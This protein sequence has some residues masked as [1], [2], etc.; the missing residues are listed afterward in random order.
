MNRPYDAETTKP[1]RETIYNPIKKSLINESNTNLILGLQSNSNYRRVVETT[2]RG[3]FSDIGLL[4][5]Q[6]K[7]TRI[8]C[9]IDTSTRTSVKNGKDDIH[10]VA[11]SPMSFIFPLNHF[12]HPTYLRSP[13]LDQK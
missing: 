11:L 1:R 13:V 6:D 10:L 9:T 3:L 7:S 5:L 8:Q 2:E 4:G 12:L